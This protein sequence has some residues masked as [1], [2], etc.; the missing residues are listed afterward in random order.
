[1]IILLGLGIVLF[2]MVVLFLFIDALGN[3]NTDK[4]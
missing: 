1:M 3:E 2:I 4:K